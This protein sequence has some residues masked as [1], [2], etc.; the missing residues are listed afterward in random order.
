MAGAEAQDT[1]EARQLELPG[2][3]IPLAD[4]EPP[5]GGPVAQSQGNWK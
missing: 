3:Q 5:S 4:V 2:L 1:N